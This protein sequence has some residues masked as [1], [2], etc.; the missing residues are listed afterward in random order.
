MLT[1]TKMIQHCASMA[2]Y[3][4]KLVL[5]VATGKKLL[6]GINEFRLLL[7]DSG[8]AAVVEGKQ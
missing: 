3:G 6:A 4:Q 1:F 7:E 2:V 8:E 5:G